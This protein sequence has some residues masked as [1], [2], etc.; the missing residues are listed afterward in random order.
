MLGTSFA[1]ALLALAAGA[2]GASAQPV[3][4]SL[5]ARLLVALT[6][7]SITE[8]VIDDVTLAIPPDVP[9]ADAVCWMGLCFAELVRAEIASLAARGEL[10]PV[11]VGNRGVGAA[12]S[13]DWDPNDFRVDD[14]HFVANETLYGPQG[15][16]YNIPAADVVVHYVGTN[17]AVAFF[18]EGPPLDVREYAAKIADFA[19]TLRRRGV[20]H[21]LLVAPPVPA[22][23]RGTEQGARLQ[24]YA[25]G[26]RE[27]CRRIAELA[28]DSPCLIDAAREFP[29]EGWDRNAIHP[30]AAG[31]A[32]LARMVLDA[33]VPLLAERR[34]ELP[35]PTGAD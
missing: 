10:G 8:G 1:A 23:W 18:E 12:T 19:I 5:D 31:H 9:P 32:F 30:N 25:V 27:A 2:G 34:V 16:F 24:G 20:A 35:V 4:P 3:A 21:V 13:R 15:L 11:L 14:L 22:A 33:I 7:D 17:D 28:P 6:G 26:V 29:A